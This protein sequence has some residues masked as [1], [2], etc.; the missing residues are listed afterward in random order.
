MRAMTE[1]QKDKLWVDYMVTQLALNLTH[2][3]DTPLK[4]NGLQEF[5]QSHDDYCRLPVERT[6]WQNWHW[7][8][9]HRVK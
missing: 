4:I 3:K 1:K 6:N 8:W 2:F 5:R 7:K 9:G